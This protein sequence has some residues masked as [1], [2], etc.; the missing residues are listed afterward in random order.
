MKIMN[1]EGCGRNISC[2]ILRYYSGMCIKGLGV[3]KGQA[4]HLP[5][6]L[7]KLKNKEVY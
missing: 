7:K 5:P 6:G 4:R 1:W 2:F 3:C